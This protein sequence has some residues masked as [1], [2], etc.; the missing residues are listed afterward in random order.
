VDDVWEIGG[1]WGGLA[2][3]FKTLCPDV[4]YL[5]TGPPE[6]LLMSAVY[7]ATLFPASRTRFYD[8]TCADAFWEDWQNV[9]F[10]FGPESVVPALRP[11]SLDLVVDN[12]AMTEM[13]PSRAEYHAARAHAL[14]CRYFLTTSPPPEEDSA[15]LPVHEI[16]G[17]FYW[18]H[19]LAVP[20]F[21]DWR[22]V[23]HRR[24]FWLGWRRLHT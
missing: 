22:L 24:Q 16:A 17:R 11:P 5:I 7:L 4:T 9:D 12:S 13:T 15:G 20:D 23:A 6:M 18:P 3:H 21:L 2:Y 10:A 8:P 14:G 19:A 1:G